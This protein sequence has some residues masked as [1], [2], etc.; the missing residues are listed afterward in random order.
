MHVWVSAECQH[1]FRSWPVVYSM[2][3]RH[4]IACTNILWKSSRHSNFYISNCSCSNN[5]E[6]ICMYRGP[7]NT[8][9]PQQN[10]GHFAYHILHA[11]FLSKIQWSVFLGVQLTISRYWLSR[12]VITGTNVNQIS[13][14]QHGVTG[15]QCVES[16]CH[17]RVV[18]KSAMEVAVT[19]RPCG[20]LTQK[21]QHFR[22]KNESHICVIL[23]LS[24]VWPCIS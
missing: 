7:R 19:R 5:F 6:F 17:P 21:A 1:W 10:S 8:S 16:I 11:F 2:T 18:R 22:R 12:K 14:A 24:H 15:P 13:M 9:R 20:T 4:L 23:S 3:N